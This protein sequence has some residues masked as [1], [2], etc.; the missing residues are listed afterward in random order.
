MRL[1]P[2]RQP[3]QIMHSYPIIE[4][5]CYNTSLSKTVGYKRQNWATAHSDKIC[6]V[7]TKHDY[8]HPIHINSSFYLA[9]RSSKETVSSAT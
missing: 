3:N 6:G 2:W 4:Q 7:H 8:R 9:S 5:E 1:H